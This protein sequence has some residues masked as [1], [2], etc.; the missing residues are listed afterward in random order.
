MAD[1]K[2]LSG[3]LADRGND[4]LV[5][6]QLMRLLGKIRTRG[7]R[8][9]VLAEPRLDIGPRHPAVGRIADPIAHEVTPPLDRQS[10]HRRAELA[11]GCGLGI[12]PLRCHGL[13][14]PGCRHG[15]KLSARAT[16]LAISR[17]Q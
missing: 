15:R 17:R 12:A 1:A 16:A 9:T 14:L 11:P 8:A 6:R 5:A 10:L 13:V 4:P 3:L 7:C 2:D